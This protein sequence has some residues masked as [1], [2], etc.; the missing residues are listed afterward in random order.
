VTPNYPRPKG[1]S[2]LRVS[3]IP[4]YAACTSPN[5][6]H[7]APLAFPS[8]APPSQESGFLTVGTPDANGAGSNSFGSIVLRTIVGNPST[9]ADEADIDVKASVTD[10]RN[11]TS[12]TDYT[13]QLQARIPVRITD[14][15]NPPP[16]GGSS[17][18]TTEI[19]V[20]VFT[21]PCAVTSDATV[22]STCSVATTADAI[23]PGSLK[24]GRRT[25]W[26]L[27]QIRVLDGGPDGVVST[28]DNTIFLRQGVFAP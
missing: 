28:S 10:V 23:T 15:D 5:R 11:K 9:P 4:A 22:G 2:P 26:E 24:E 6:T 13:G 18:G 21:I 17:A 3:L 27:G 14:L 8:C 7:G 20:F 19:A 16:S 12:L 1:A 25:I